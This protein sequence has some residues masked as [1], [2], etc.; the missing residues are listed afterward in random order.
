MKIRPRKTSLATKAIAGF[1]R[2]ITSA[3]DYQ[4]L[5][6]ETEAGESVGPRWYTDAF[7]G[8]YTDARETIALRDKPA[9]QDKPTVEEVSSKRYRTMES[10]NKIGSAYGT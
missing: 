9:L 10:S 8:P 5:D 6:D 2:L 7:T 3:W 4:T 1:K